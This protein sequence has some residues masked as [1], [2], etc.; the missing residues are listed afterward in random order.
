MSVAPNKH[1]KDVPPAVERSLND[2]RV[3]LVADPEL[4]PAKLHEFI[5]EL[6]LTPDQADDGTVLQVTGDGHLLTGGCVMGM[7]ARDG[8]EPPT[9]AFSGPRSTS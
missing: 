5:P 4:S 9:P 7:V 8:I 2:L 1:L 3:L 6:L